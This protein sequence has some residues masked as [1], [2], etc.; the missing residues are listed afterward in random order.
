M[1]Y[2]KSYFYYF[3]EYLSDLIYSSVKKTCHSKSNVFDGERILQSP[4]ELAI[5][6][7][8]LQ[9]FMNECA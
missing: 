4:S 7:Y 3:A 6:K 2:F 9:T 1:F 5:G 8:C